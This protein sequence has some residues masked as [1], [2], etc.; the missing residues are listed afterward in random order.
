MQYLM[1]NLSEVAI[2]VCYIR[3]MAC[4][5]GYQ[6]FAERLRIGSQHSGTELGAVSGTRRRV[7][8]Q[9]KNETNAYRE[10]V[11]LNQGGI[12]HQCECTVDNE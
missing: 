3:Y 8:I 4:L 6:D 12:T 7:T 9:Q 2:R 10:H 11:S 5:C 1:K